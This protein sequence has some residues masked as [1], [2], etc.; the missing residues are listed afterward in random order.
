[1]LFGQTFERNESLGVYA[2]HAW[3]WK[4]NPSGIFVGYNPTVSCS[5]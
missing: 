1:V 3:V 2:L 5:R 4:N